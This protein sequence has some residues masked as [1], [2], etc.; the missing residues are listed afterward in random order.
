MKKKNLDP[1]VFFWASPFFLPPRGLFLFLK[2]V[3]RPCRAL[4]GHG[5]NWECLHSQRHLALGAPHLHLS[6]SFFYLLREIRENSCLKP[7]NATN[8]NVPLRACRH[9]P[10]LSLPPTQKSRKIFGCIKKSPYLCI[11]KIKE[12]IPDATKTSDINNSNISNISN[13]Q[14]I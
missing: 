3:A 8:S 10:P 13:F 6:I 12:T 14:T 11:V 5:C 2:G 1:L 7:Q 9:F 4:E